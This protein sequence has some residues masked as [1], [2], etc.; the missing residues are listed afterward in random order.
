MAAIMLLAAQSSRNRP[1]R[2]AAI[3]GQAAFL[4]GDDMVLI[5]MVVLTA[6]GTFS[7]AGLSGSGRGKGLNTRMKENSSRCCRNCLAIAFAR[8]VW[9]AWC[10]CFRS[11]SPGE[12]PLQRVAPLSARL[13][14]DDS[15][16]QRCRHACNG[17][18]R[19]GS[20][21]L[22]ARSRRGRPCMS[23]HVV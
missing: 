17:I 18:L 5:R 20:A 22:A 11:P 9:S 2:S 4:L 23:C 7:A 3:C 21:N 14:E 12:K 16:P 13:F 10:F 15:Q 8:S 1:R 6:I 19:E